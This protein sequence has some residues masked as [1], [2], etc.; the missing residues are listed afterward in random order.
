MNYDMAAEKYLQVRNQ[1]EE[2]ERLHKIAKAEQTEKL[3]ALENWMTAKAQEDGLETVKTPHGTAYWSTHH[4]AT[5]G[6]REEFFNFCKE[7]DAWDMV[8][9]RASKT[10]VKSYIEANGAPPPGVNFSST[11]VFNLRKAQSK[12]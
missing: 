11:R 5:V 7:H 9:S 10:G 6:S 3:I 12:E 8:E 1:I 4:T 2:M